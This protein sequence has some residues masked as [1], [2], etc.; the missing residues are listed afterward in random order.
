[1][2]LARSD[3]SLL[4]Q[5]W[6]TVDRQLFAAIL[7]LAAA[8]I[9]VSLIASP[10]VAM[11]QG[12]GPFFYVKRH[13]VF[14]LTGC[15]LIFLLSL[16]R[17][18]EVR[19]ASLAIFFGAIAM[20]AL[21]LWIG[22]EIK[23]AQRWLV[24]MGQQLQPSELMKPALV[25]LSAWLLAESTRRSDVPALPLSLALYLV[26]AAL[27]VLQ[28]DIGQTMLITLVWATML[29]LSGQ[30]LTRMALVIG[31]GVLALVLAYGSFDHV[32]SRIDRFLN[33][34]AGDTYQMDRA[35]Q[36]FVEGGWLGRGPGEGT[37]KSTL[38][39]AHTDYVYAVIAEEYG[40][41]ACLA[42]L[43][44]YG[45]IVFRALGHVWRRSDGFTRHAVTGLSLL[46][47]L[48]A[49]INMGVNAGLLPAKGMTLPFV[50]YGGSS[51]IGM[52]IA[53]GFLLALTR[54]RPE[55]TRPK[56]TIFLGSEDVAE[57]GT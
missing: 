53:M 57:Q 29:F 55:P 43:A 2:R 15:A 47:G 14:A 9:M 41:I 28:P 25:V 13:L 51:L 42:L 37:I 34:A 8:G 18:V 33:P 23:G 50:S 52:A 39:D 36:S 35:R 32:R 16:F 24:L 54:R 17:P 22:P 26:S 10:A 56:N 45:F 5:W 30:S 31:A 40:A 46:I 1:M 12:I 49:L 21:A 48:Q 3:R 20:M 6:F 7:A 4:A 44:A 38:P 27:L 11:K 19:R